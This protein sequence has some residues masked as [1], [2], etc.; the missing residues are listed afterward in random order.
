MN[1]GLS[2]E[3]FN[4]FVRVVETGE[5][6]RCGPNVTIQEACA[7]FLAIMHQRLSNRQAQERFQHSGSTI[8]IA[9]REVRTVVNGL[10]TTFTKSEQL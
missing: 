6:V 1:S 10:R 9:F 3:L 5:N 4:R 7:I 8:T 2:R